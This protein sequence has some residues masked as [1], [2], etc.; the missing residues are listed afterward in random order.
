MSWK[1]SEY[2]DNDLNGMISITKENYG[3]IEI[4]NED[5]LDWQYFNNPAGNALIKLA[6]SKSNEVVGQYI[7]IPMKFKVDKDVINS[8]LSLNTLTRKDYRGKGIFTGL[9]NDI[10][11]QCQEEGIEFT[12]GF[13]NPNSYPG[14]IKKLGFTDLGEIPLMLFPLNIENLVLKKFNIKWLSKISG[15]FQKLFNISSKKTSEIE[16]KHIN[17]N[18]EDFNDFWENIKDKYKV[19]GIRNSEYIS[20]RYNNVPLRNYKVIGA[21]RNK[22]LSGYI[23]LR[24]TNIEQFKCGMIV[25]FIIKEG[26]KESGISLLSEACKIFNNDNME[27]V[28]C[29]MNNSTE[30]YKLL[31]NCSFYRCPK[32]LEPQPFKVIYRNHL[33]KENKDLNDINDWFLTMGD[34][35]VI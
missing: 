20:W 27:L 29:L 9:A 23:V 16:L 13:P 26:D 2:E 22:R 15:V 33:N 31:K 5:F 18:F 12:Y 6:K 14:F 7:I 17:N 24:N 4:S 8:T 35:D 11:S 25:D 32:F 28:G 34:Y 10:Y 1:V 21:Y 30:E 19:I 3:D